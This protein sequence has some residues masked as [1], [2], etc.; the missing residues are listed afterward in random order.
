MQ[1]ILDHALG[2]VLAKGGLQYGDGGIGK[3]ISW[4]LLVL[5][6]LHR[7][8]NGIAWAFPLHG[9]MHESSYV[10]HVLFFAQC[11]TSSRNSNNS[12]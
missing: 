10:V 9:F 11:C 8:L 3:L 1:A 6:M 4:L 7:W 2:E 5:C 12:G